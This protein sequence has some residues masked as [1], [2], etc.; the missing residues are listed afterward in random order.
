MGVRTWRISRTRPRPSHRPVL[1]GSR[2]CGPGVGRSKDSLCAERRA[3]ATRRSRALEPQCDP[4]QSGGVLW[5]KAL[6]WPRT[7]GD[8]CDDETR[9]FEVISRWSG[10]GK[11][12][13]ATSCR[14]QIGLSKTSASRADVPIFRSS[15][16]GPDGPG[17]R[18]LSTTAERVV[19]SVRSGALYISRSSAA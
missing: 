4:A 16:A 15:R 5:P 1:P 10:A 13:S 3:L 19:Q 17:R 7:S 2:R 11:C 18:A 9:R 6:A 8:A 14:E 12:N